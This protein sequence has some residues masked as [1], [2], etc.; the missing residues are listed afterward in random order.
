MTALTPTPLWRPKPV[1]IPGNELEFVGPYGAVTVR[2]LPLLTLGTGWYEDLRI[3]GPNGRRRNLITIP[4]HGKG[5]APISKGLSYPPE[6]LTTEEM[7]HLL[8]T[9][10]QDTINGVRNRSLLALL[11]RTGL[12]ISE[13]LDLRPHHVDFQAK[14]V[15]VLRGKGTKA[16]TV[17]ID[18]YGLF[19][20]QPWLFERATLGISAKA[21]LFCTTQLPG[22][23]N[24]VYSAHIRV[25]LHRYARAADIPKR[26]HPHGLRHALA[27]GLIREGF[28][29]AHVSAQLGHADLATTCIYLRTLG[30]D[31]AFDAIGER[32][33]PG[34]TPTLT[35]RTTA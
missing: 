21:P 2:Q 6:P 32:A 9:I 30:S 12:R 31:E 7:L 25:V 26:V 22:R 8:A 4:G 19:A 23:G 1:E 3:V 11:W 20:L 29:L 16:R 13:G 24:R 35:E 34:A 14:R 28:S 33:W 10:P 27:V 15:T 17:G 5:T 18:E